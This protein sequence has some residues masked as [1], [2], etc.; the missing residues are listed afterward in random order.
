[1]SRKKEI[2]FN[3]RLKRDQLERGRTSKEVERKFN[4]SWN[5]FYKNIQNYLNK[6][7]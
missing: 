3:R 1:M 6:N 2:C 5:L 7:R 4:K